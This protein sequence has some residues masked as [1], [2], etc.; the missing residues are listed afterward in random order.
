ML[1]LFYTS[2]IQPTAVGVWEADSKSVGIENK[3]QIPYVEKRFK[4]ARVLRL[5]SKQRRK[6]INQEREANMKP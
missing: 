4:S 6:T 2:E 1:L 3:L 5:D